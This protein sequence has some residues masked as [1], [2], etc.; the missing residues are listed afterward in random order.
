MVVTTVL[1]CFLNNMFNF[2]FFS[3]KI[4]ITHIYSSFKVMQ[5]FILLSAVRALI[6]SVIFEGERSFNSTS[7]ASRLMSAHPPSFLPPPHSPSPPRFAPNH[8]QRPGREPLPS[9][10]G[11]G[12][13][14]QR[15]GSLRSEDAAARA[16]PL[17]KGMW[18]GFFVLSND[19]HH[20]FGNRRRSH[21]STAITPIDNDDGNRLRRR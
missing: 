2:A 19:N 10:E 7:T 6:S 13:N 9:F 4:C 3:L 20:H 1:A 14:K 5:L 12:L 21:R 11:C 15:I 17:S 16:P 8:T 18:A